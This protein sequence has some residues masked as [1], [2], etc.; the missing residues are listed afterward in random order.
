[1]L[2]TAN[3]VPSES[4]SDGVKGWVYNGK[5]A[6]QTAYW[7]CEKDGESSI[8]T[9]DIDEYFMVIEGEYIL[10]LEGRR[11]VLHKG[12]EYHISKGIP[13]SGKFRAGTRTFHCFGGKRV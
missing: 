9:H 6:K 3:A 5:D 12:D 4:Q 2:T 7:L 10:Q 8:H 11:I 1:M 13:H